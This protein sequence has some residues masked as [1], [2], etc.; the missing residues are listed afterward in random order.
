MHIIL[1][2]HSNN[3]EISIQLSIKRLD[4]C[5][6]DLCKWMKINALK[7]NEEKTEFIIFGVH[8]CGCLHRAG[9]FEVAIKKTINC[10]Y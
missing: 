10:F 8:P 5:R 1:Y 9:L 6:A 7:L 2:A 4:Y 3:D